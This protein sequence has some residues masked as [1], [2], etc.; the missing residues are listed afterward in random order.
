[1]KRV[2][3]S[4]ACNYRWRTNT[5]GHGHLFQRR[6]WDKPITS[7]EQFLTTL[8]YVEANALRAGLVSRAEDWPWCSL[9]E[10]LTGNVSGLLS[11]SP[12]VLPSDW[13]EVVNL[14]QS[15]ETI[16]RILEELIRKPGRPKGRKSDPK[17]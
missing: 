7:A 16:Y 17:Q 4:Y 1:M 13:C 6:F 5:V 15:E 8:R 11:S 10:R 12:I 2:A 14:P 9:H 3:G